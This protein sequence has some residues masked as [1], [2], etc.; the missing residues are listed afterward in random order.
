MINEIKIQDIENYLRT[1]FNDNSHRL[2][3][4]YSVKKVAI[5]LGKI[6]HADIPSVIV[7]SYLHDATKHES[8]EE[9]LRLIGT[10]L[11]DDVPKACYHAYSASQLAKQRFGIEDLDILNAIKYH[12]SGRKEMSLLEKIIYVSD[13]IEEGRDFVDD[14]LR[15]LAMKDL[16]LTVLKIMLRTKEYILKNHQSFSNLTEDAIQYYQNKGELNE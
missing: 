2:L 12:C 8:N 1:K 5:I 14:D 11:S 3:H 9:N 10:L 4:I 13:F 16:D 7:A 15:E 6:Y